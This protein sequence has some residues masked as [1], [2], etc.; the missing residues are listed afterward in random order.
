MYTL[1]LNGWVQ[2]LVEGTNYF[3]VI[4]ALQLYQTKQIVS[5]HF[6]KTSNLSKIHIKGKLS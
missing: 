2:R 3:H 6:R 5:L 4:Q 1:Y